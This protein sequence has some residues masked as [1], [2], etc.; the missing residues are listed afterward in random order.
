MEYKRGRLIVLEGI[1]GA[2]KGTQTRKLV[3][4]LTVA[5]YDS[6]SIEFPQYGKNIFADT[7]ASLLNGD[8]GNTVE[9]NPYLASLP[10]A[11][12]RKIAAPFIEQE[13][14]RGTILVADRYV[15][16]STGHQGSKI[17]DKNGRFKFYEWQRELEY[18]KKG[19][20]IPR[21][22]LTLL[23]RTDPKVSY[24]LTKT[25]QARNYTGGEQADKAE[26][27]FEHQRK[28]AEAFLETANSE[29]SWRIINCMNPENT[30]I[31]PPEE[32]ADLIWNTVNPFLPPLQ[33]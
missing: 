33:D 8:F 5:G 13:I 10:Y 14:E 7:V 6:E 32:I 17:P 4:R 2:G 25:K 30:N 29:P 20:G 16:A 11:C 9:I 18:G 31:L 3:K 12:D 26:R 27:D 21:P 22:D 28:T 19:F 1:D 23:L 15:S 24:E